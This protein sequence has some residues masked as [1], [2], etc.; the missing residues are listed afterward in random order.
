MMWGYPALK[1]PYFCPSIIGLNFQILAWGSQLIDRDIP[2]DLIVYL[3]LLILSFNY[4]RG[5][6]SHSISQKH[7]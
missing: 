7:I 4:H 3:H 2:L 1:V 6:E 5:T